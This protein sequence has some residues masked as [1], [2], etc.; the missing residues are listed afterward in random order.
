MQVKQPVPEYFLRPFVIEPS[1]QA[2]R[3][4]HMSL[5]SMYKKMLFSYLSITLLSGLFEV[6]YVSQL[7]LSLIPPNTHK[8]KEN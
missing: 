1:G 5:Y 6:L 3:N 8:K 2:T 7:F 4:K